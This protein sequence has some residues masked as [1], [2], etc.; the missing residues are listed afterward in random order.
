MPENYEGTA[1]DPETFGQLDAD[2]EDDSLDEEVDY[3]DEI[4]EE[5]DEPESAQEDNDETNEEERQSSFDIEGIGTVTA[6]EIKE[7]RNSGLR[8]SD[9]TRKTQELAQQREELKDAAAVYDYLKAH[10]YLV[11]S[12]KQAERNPQFNQIAPSAEKDA[13][14]GLQY[15]VQSMRVDSELQSLHEKYGDFD[16]DALFRTATENKTNNLEMVLKS[17]MYESKPDTSTVE[18][19]KKQLRDELKAELEQN[20]DTVSTVVTN[21]SSKRRSTPRLTKEEKHVAEMMG[22]TPSEYNKWKNI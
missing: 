16:E 8:Q 13:I 3:D 7:W 22:M 9:Y 6:D 14:R 10:P 21:K 11:D 5:I 12:I 2:T 19:L 15:Q 17:M 1:I 4:D 18:Q 20:R